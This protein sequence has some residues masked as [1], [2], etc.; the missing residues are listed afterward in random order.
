MTGARFQRHA[1]VGSFPR[2]SDLERRRPSG[3][4]ARPARI[5]SPPPA[6]WIGSASP[7]STPLRFARQPTRTWS[8]NRVAGLEIAE[9]GMNPADKPDSGEGG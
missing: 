3:C 8:W 5:P 6:S 4:Q 1:R 2:E 7:R 9:P